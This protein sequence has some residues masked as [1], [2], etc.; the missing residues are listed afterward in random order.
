MIKSNSMVDGVI[1]TPLNIIDV[2]GGDVLHAMKKSD[3][4][5]S[6]FGEAYFSTI[7]YGAIKAWKRH[8]SMTLNLVVCFGKVRFVIFDDR[9]DLVNK[10]LYNEIILSR[11]NYCRL[12]IPPSVWLGFQG[13]GDNTSM[14]LNIANIQHDPKEMN[15]KEQN[16]INYDWKII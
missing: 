12:T 7:N 3:P 11:K 10:P 6:G 14:L 13:I 16:E 9:G 15:R 1:V 8:N 4:G 2:E 5:Y